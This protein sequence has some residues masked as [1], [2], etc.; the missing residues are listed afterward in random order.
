M[1]DIKGERLRSRIERY[2]AEVPPG[3]EG[4]ALE[5]FQALKAALNGGSLRAAFRSRRR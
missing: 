4:A 1:S 2:A 5:A 3:E